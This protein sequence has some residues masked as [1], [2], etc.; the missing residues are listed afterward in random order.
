MMLLQSS[1][2]GKSL[3]QSDSS[4]NLERK[5]ELKD[6]QDIKAMITVVGTIMV[7]VIVMLTVWLHRLKESKVSRITQNS[8]LTNETHEAI[9]H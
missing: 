5:I 3:H 6:I 4:G 7:M 8:C 1:V 2:E 9:T